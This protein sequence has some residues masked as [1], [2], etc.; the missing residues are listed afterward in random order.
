ML[1]HASDDHNMSSVDDVEKRDRRADEDKTRQDRTG[2][3]ETGQH[4]EQ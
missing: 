1:F 3:A 4:K 2:L